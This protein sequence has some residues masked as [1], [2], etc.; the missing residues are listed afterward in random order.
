M[1]GE[2]SPLPVTSQLP[3]FMSTLR[4]CECFDLARVISSSGP[5]IEGLLCA[6]GFFLLFCFLFSCITPE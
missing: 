2:E 1:E 4:P 5:F 3:S 6:L